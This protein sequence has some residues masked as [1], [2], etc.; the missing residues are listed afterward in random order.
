MGKFLEFPEDFNWGASTA[1]VQVEGNTDLSHWSRYLD[2]NAN[3]LADKGTE[4]FGLYSWIEP[5]TDRDW[6]EK[7]ASD[8]DNYVLGEAV[9]HYNRYPE[10]FD[11]L[12]Q[13]GLD[14][15]RFSLEWSR[16]MKSPGE[17][18]QDQI[19]HY[20]EFL[21]ELKNR[22]ITTFVTLWHFSNPVWFQNDIGWTSAESVEHFSRYARKMAE[23]LGDLV[24]YWITINE[25]QVYTGNAY[26]SGGWPPQKKNPWSYYRAL[27]NL[28]DAH[29]AG[30]TAIKQVRP[31]A[32]VGFSKNNGSV[33]APRFLQLPAKMFDY[34]ANHYP[35][36]KAGDKL[37]FIGLNHYFNE[38]LKLGINGGKEPERSDLGWRLEPRSIYQ[39]LKELERYDLPVYITE[40]GVADRDDR[41]REWFI[42]ES[43][44]YV[45]RAIQEG[46]DVRGYLHWSLLDN[47]EWDQGRWPRF[48][49]V[50]VD[51]ENG[52]ERNIRDSAHRYAEI[53]RNNGIEHSSR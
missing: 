3:D 1:S 22:D 40:H 51:Y 38:V 26:L 24:D 4:R 9:D 5:E 35:I 37:D 19:E 39:T 48:G 11:I 10:D 32:K 25:P 50:E 20:R 7:R 2:S 43:L 47:I 17:F 18:D 29:R 36:Q 52:L 41:H 28:M 53:A 46:I 6:V 34:W 23:E 14:S 12:Q 30:Y 13:L 45:H 49:L 27:N 8:P 15:Y 42:E 44:Q 21:Q 33:E 16:V 31:D